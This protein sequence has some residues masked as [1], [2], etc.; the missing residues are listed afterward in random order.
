MIKLPRN[1]ILLAQKQTRVDYGTLGVAAILTVMGVEVEKLR[2]VIITHLGELAA[3][4]S[5]WSSFLSVS[6]AS[7]SPRRFAHSGRQGRTE[8]RRVATEGKGGV[9]KKVAEE[10]L[11][12]GRTG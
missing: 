12:G 4:V 5:L 6:R 3:G 9:T 11:K 10:K 1:L 7:L 2:K 8:R